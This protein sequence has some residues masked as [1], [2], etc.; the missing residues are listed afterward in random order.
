M[1]NKNLLTTILI[2]GLFLFGNTS[3]G[4]TTIAGWT[5]PT[6]SGD[7]PK[8][9]PAECGVLFEDAYIYAD[10]TNYSD[11]WDNLVYFSGSSLSK[12]CDVTTATGALSL[13]SQTNNNKSIIFKLSTV[14][15]GNLLLNYDTRG[16][17]T[18]FTTHVWS[19][20]VDDEDFTIVKTITGRNDTNF[21]TQEVDFSSFTHLNDESVVF[22]KLTVFGA[23]SGSGNNRLDN[24]NFTAFDISVTD[25]VIIATPT[26]INFENV[27]VNQSSNFEII[28]VSGKNL[29][30]DISYSLTGDI[31]EFNIIDD[32]WNPSS[33]GI[34]SVSFKPTS[35]RNFNAIITFS[36][37]DA[38]DKTVS[39]T[40]TGYEVEMQ[41]YNLVTSIEQMESGNRY[42]IVSIFEE[43][44]WALGWQKTNNRHA[45]K[46]EASGN[47]I[48]TTPAVIVTPSQDEVYPYE[49]TISF[50]DEYWTLFDGLNGRYLRPFTGNNNYLQLSNE[51]V[52]WELEIENDGI[53]SLICKDEAYT[54]NVMRFN[55]N[56]QNNMPLFACYLPTFT[57]YEEMYIYKVSPASIQKKPLDNKLEIYPNPF[58]DV[59][60]FSN[61]L[62]VE[63]VTVT[64][65]VGQKVME[66]KPIDGKI[67]MRS[68]NSGIYL[69][70]VYDKKGK[71]VV[72][73]V[74]K[75]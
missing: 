36:S 22:I 11:D 40:G 67:D 66:V 30:D 71:V 31:S 49:L 5:F 8:V 7:A 51:K 64:N 46:V 26:N 68:L 24:V 15:Y 27:I 59:L 25:P 63:K 37:L 23:T 41:T 72:K 18:G 38:E 45:V 3:W 6:A 14:G 73:K 20:S 35:A 12:L 61:I 56:Q 55:P 69:I 32:N 62:D 17:A 33:G 44:Y 4:Q 52:F 53:V 16:T 29:T 42:L 19:Y 2:A 21:S 10:G 48:T 47:T 1:K 54:R 43:K 57:G 58:N 75:K 70:S 28:T 65:I 34:L 74:V 60:N 39:L 9:H 50:E 13:V